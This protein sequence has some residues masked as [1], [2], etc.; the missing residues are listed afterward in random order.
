MCVVA[1]VVVPPGV[2]AG[3]AGRD[4]KGNR[5]NGGDDAAHF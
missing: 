1:M 2:S 3:R 4:Q 5:Q